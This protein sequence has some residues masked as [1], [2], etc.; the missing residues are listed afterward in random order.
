MRA[1]GVNTWDLS[2][3]KAARLREGMNLQFRG[4]FLN[5]WNHPMF[6]APNT[7]PTSSAFGMVSSQR[8][9]PRGIQLGLKLLF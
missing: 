6:N 8:A 5:A 9:F 2:A 1:D 3:I 7:S 4:E